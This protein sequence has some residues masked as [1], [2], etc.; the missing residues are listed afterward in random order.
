[1]HH[2]QRPHA[3]PPVRIER[4]CQR[5]LCYLFLGQRF[6]CNQSCRGGEARL[7]VVLDATE[8]LSSTFKKANRSDFLP[9]AEVTLKL[10]CAALNGQWDELM[11]ST[12]SSKKPHASIPMPSLSISSSG[13]S[14]R[15]RK[16]GRGRLVTPIDISNTCLDQWT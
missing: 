9:P 3:L 12:A 4:L 11:R 6:N 7:L 16:R 5:L 8:P 14:P 2:H 1:M 15:P 13:L 10:R